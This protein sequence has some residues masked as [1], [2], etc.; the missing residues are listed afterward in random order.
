MVKFHPTVSQIIRV[1]WLAT[2]CEPL[3]MHIPKF[4]VATMW[5]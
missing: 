3:E 2:A 5:P 1:F 4:S